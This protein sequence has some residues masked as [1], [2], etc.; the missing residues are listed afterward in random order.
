LLAFDVDGELT[1]G[2]L[3]Q[4]VSLEEVRDR[5]GFDIRVAPDLRVLPPPSADELRAFSALTGDAG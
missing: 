2:A 4:G 1:L 5:T 3:H